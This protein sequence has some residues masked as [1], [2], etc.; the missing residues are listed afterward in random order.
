MFALDRA[1]V[2]LGSILS[3]QTNAKKRG[4]SYLG[5]EGVIANI[6]QEIPLLFEDILSGIKGGSTAWGE[7]ADNSVYQLTEFEVPTSGLIGKFRDAV[8][9]NKTVTLNANVD[10][11]MDEMTYT[12][13]GY[14]KNY[15]QNKVRENIIIYALARAQKPTGRLNVDDVKRASGSVNI[16]GMQSDERVS[17][18]LEEV[19]TFINRGI[20]SIY[21]QGYQKN[22]KG[23]NVNI[24]DTNQAV[25]EVKERMELNLGIQPPEVNKNQ[26]Q[27]QNQ[28]Q[29]EPPIEEDNDGDEETISLSNEE[30]FSRGN[31]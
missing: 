27:N 8:G 10:M 1:A 16:S 25:K 11:L 17:A 18:Q 13:L 30:I 3:S 2:T 4:D 19:L 29:D 6:Y 24:F 15:A 12:N 7:P 5:I 22:T 21:N 9:S 20:Q 26:N 14:D 31:I 23:E 28:N